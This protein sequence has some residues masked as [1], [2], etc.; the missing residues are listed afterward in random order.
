MRLGDKLP[1]VVVLDPDGERMSLRRAVHG[2]ALL[3]FLRH[4]T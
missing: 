2:P 3:I 1:D 4:L